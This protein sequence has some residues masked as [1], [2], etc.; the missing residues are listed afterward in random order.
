M[1]RQAGFSA[2]SGAGMLVS[3]GDPEAKYT[4]LETIGKGGFGTVCMAVETATGEEVA[5]KKISLLQESSNE[6]CVNEIQVMRHHKN[7]QPGELRRQL[8]LAS[9]LSSRLS[10]AN[11]DQL[12]GLLTGWRPEIFTSKP[13][14]P[15][16][17]IWS[18]G[19]VGME[20]VEGAPPYLMKTSR[21]VR[22]LISSGG[23]PKLQ[24]P[25]QQ[26]AWLR[27]F[28]RCCLETDEDRRWSAQ[29]LLQTLRALDTMLE[30]MVFSS[31]AFRVDE[32]LRIFEFWPVK[33][34]GITGL[35]LIPGR[36][37]C[38]PLGLATSCAWQL[39]AR[40]HILYNK[41]YLLKPNFRDLSSAF[42]HTVLESTAEKQFLQEAKNT[43][44]ST[45]T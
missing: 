10:G 11:G 26:S 5:I 38:P 7:G 18:F 36:R 21:T 37:D 32:V 3:E 40:P 29:E 16:V 2:G 24:N 17:D 31:P 4:E 12:S 35:F 6:L 41:P 14:G 34:V 25:R 39:K 28:L 42:I 19:I 33:R 8:I 20:M 1:G 13:Y 30:A 15:K 9:L 22:Q 44:F 43:V 45:R 23:T 27:D